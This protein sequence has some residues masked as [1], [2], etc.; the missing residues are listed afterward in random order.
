MTGL[1]IAVSGTLSGKLGGAGASMA[2]AVAT[3]G[4]V[5]AVALLGTR[6]RAGGAARAAG[7]PCGRSG[8]ACSA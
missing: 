6:V 1:I 4:D 5:L 2:G 3:G 7:R 8:R